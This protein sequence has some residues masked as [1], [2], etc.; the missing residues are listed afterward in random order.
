MRPDIISPFASCVNNH[1]VL[2]RNLARSPDVATLGVRIYESQRSAASAYNDALAKASPGSEFT[3]FVHQDMYLPQGWLDRL[4]ENVAYLDLHDP[5][6]GV[7]GCFG[8][9]SGGQYAGHVYSNGI[10]LLGRPFNEPIR[11]RTLDEIVLVVR[12]MPVFRFTDGHPGFHLY[13]TD[14]CLRAEQIGLS[15]YVV[16]NYCVHNTEQWSILPREF[17]RG[18]RAIMR[19]HPTALPVKATC[20][21]ICKDIWPMRRAILR[22]TIA[23]WRGDV[24]VTRRVPDPSAFA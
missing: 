15:C 17:Y 7:I 1:D 16:D 3:I 22:H 9:T 10:G 6:W 18:Y 5:S 21:T 24:S 2:K 8:V 19:H 4:R 14:I 20:A 11:V 23:K 12:H 13:G